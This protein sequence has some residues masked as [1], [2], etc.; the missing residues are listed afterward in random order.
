MR[1]L[2][3]CL[4]NICRSPLAEG[5][6]RHKAA[7]RNLDWQIDSAG[8][9]EWH[10]GH[11]P[12]QRSI[13]TALRHGIDISEQR[14]RL[15]QKADFERFDKIL[16]MDSRNL[17][18]VLRLAKTDE[19]RAKVERILQYSHPGEDRSVPDPYLDDDGF[20]AVFVMLNVACERFLD[21]TIS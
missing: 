8:T 19:Q 17:R 1:I 14:G 20:E 16:V 4:G 15:F 3:V 12:D 11:S 21:H 10:I 7:Q 6:L 13:A 9:G 2:L 5:I 18:D